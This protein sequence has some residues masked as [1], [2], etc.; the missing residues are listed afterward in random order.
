MA[1][2]AE[3]FVSTFSQRFT[4]FTKEVFGVVCEFRIRKMALYL[5]LLYIF[6]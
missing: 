4:L 1:I 2:A 6:R 3:A 5:A